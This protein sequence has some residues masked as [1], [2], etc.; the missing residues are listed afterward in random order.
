VPRVEDDRIYIVQTDKG[1]E[2]LTVGEFARRY[3]WKNEPDK[4]W[5]AAP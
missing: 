2:T 1:Q 5:P 3:G 4:V